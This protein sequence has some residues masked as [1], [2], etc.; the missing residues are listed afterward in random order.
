MTRVAIA[1]AFALASLGAAAPADAATRTCSGASGTDRNT[2][3]NW[4]D[5]VVPAS[6]DD[7]VFQ[8][9]PASRDSNN[10]IAGWSIASV[11]VTTTNSGADYHFT[12]ACR[13]AARRSILS[14]R[15][16]RCRSA[17]RSSTTTGRTPSSAPTT[18]SRMARR[19]SNSATGSPITYAGGDG[20]D[21]VLTSVVAPVQAPVLPVPGPSPIALLLA[22]L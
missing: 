10:D 15:R 12:G 8:D 7:L 5:G 22:S 2:A 11:S 19:S 18:A 6:G 3:G 20:N 21:V 4:V 16:R 9:S 13:S 17:C 14:R 1:F